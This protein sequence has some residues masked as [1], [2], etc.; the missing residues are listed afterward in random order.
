MKTPLVEKTFGES[1]FST[2]N[3][4]D[5]D[6]FYFFF[7]LLEETIFSK[8]RIFD[9]KFRCRLNSPLIWTCCES[10]KLQARVKKLQNAFWVGVG[11]FCRL[12]PTNDPTFD[13]CLRKRPLKIKSHLTCV[14]RES[15]SQLLMFSNS[16]LFA[17]SSR[18]NK[19]RT[20]NQNGFSASDLRRITSKQYSVH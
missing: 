16:F 5:Q 2:K 19:E 11:T 15:S 12:A 17:F 9:E 3:F 7:W 6:D 13:V 18:A 1:E 14:R 20:L 4:F 10:C 8:K